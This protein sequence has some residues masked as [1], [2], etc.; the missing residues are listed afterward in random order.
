MEL[1]PFLPQTELVKYCQTKG[2]MVEAFS[3]LGSASSPVLA[4]QT[5]LDISKKYHCSP[6]QVVLSW[7]HARGVVV[8]P[9]S[10]TPSRIDEN[11]ILVDLGQHLNSS[12]HLSSQQVAIADPVDVSRISNLSQES[13]KTKRFVSHFA[14]RGVAGPTKCAISCHSHRSNR[15]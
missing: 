11:S 15:L 14:G 12:L 7:N 6:S 1:H 9:K 10:V 5:V 4:D 2:I 13:G 8:L 3:P